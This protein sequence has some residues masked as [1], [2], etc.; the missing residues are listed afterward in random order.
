MDYKPGCCDICGEPMELGV[1]YVAEYDEDE[2]QAICI[3]K[4]C[5]SYG[6]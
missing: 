3:N 1:V 2:I 6:V 5:E 4:D